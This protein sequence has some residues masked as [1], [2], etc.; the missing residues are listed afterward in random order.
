MKKKEER[1]NCEVDIFRKLILIYET[2]SFFFDVMLRII[3]TNFVKLAV[4]II[5]NVKIIVFRVFIETS[6]VFIEILCVFI[7]TS[8][9]YI[10]NHVFNVE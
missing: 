8:R 9:V 2:S 5:E 4:M 1:R 6:R 7:E 3:F 10:D